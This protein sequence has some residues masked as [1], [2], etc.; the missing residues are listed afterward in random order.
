MAEQ[1]ILSV[2]MDADLKEQ[3]ETL[4]QRLGMDFSDAVRMFAEQSLRVRGLPFPFQISEEDLPKKNVSVK[5]LSG[6]FKKYSSPELLAGEEEILSNAF[7][8]ATIDKY[9]EKYGEEQTK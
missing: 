1:A 5:D 6:I 8:R 3:V 9:R 7:E 4:Y 2:S